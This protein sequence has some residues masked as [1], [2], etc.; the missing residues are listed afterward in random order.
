MS[1]ADRTTI[2]LEASEAITARAEFLIQ[3]TTERTPVAEATERLACAR[4]LLEA[5]ALVRAMASADL[6]GQS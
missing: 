4:H 1:A 2:L 5:S 3:S 6:R